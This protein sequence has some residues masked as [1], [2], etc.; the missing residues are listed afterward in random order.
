VQAFVNTVDREHGPDLL[1]D[2][3]DLTAWL[4]KRG[5][6]PPP[7]PRGPGLHV[8]VT[9]DGLRDAREVREA[10]RDVLLAN[11]SGEPASEAF[12]IL[13]AAAARARLR[14]WFEGGVLLAEADGLDAALGTILSAAFRAR[15]DGTFDRLKACP[16]DVCGWAF[17]DR[18]PTGSAR[19]CSM[20]VCGGRT[21]ARAYYRRRSS[22]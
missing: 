12:A 11:G 22:R 4:T 1:D 8:R 18:S 19:W 14:P 16:R 9:P 10:L 5:L 6:S 20:R 15:A 13:D 7:P 2:P 3:D 17:Y 21:K